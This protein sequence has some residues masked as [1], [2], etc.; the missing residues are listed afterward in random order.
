MKPAV[1]KEEHKS[2]SVGF[3]AVWKFK[4]DFLLLR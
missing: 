3:V 4:S 1:L 2:S